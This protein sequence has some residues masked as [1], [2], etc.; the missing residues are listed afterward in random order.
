M[1]NIVRILMLSLLCILGFT[2]TFAIHTYDANSFIVQ[3]LSN[4]KNMPSTLQQSVFSFDIASNDASRIFNGSE[5]TL[6]IIGFP[7]SL[8]TTSTINLELTQSC[9][10]ASTI[11]MVGY[12][13]IPIPHV[14]TYS[15]SII[16]ETGSHIMLSY[17]N[18]DMHGWISRANGEVFVIGPNNS[19]ISEKRPHILYADGALETDQFHK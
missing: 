11:F 10:D 12:K 17:A 15:G 1:K 16:G 7:I 18:G 19:S 3:G 6:S 2:P 14:L 9:I 4:Q 5:K 8:K 13:Q